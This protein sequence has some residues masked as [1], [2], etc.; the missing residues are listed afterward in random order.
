M[1][2]AVYYNWGRWIADC[3]DRDCYASLRVFPTGEAKKMA[4]C[5]C[6][7]RDLCG[8]DGFHGL[9]FSLEWPD[10]SSIEA[11]CAPRPKKNRNW[12]P[13]E[14]IGD[15]RRENEAHGVDNPI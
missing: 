10:V 9:A 6:R 1:R 2:A 3:P 15:L 14:T 8:H 7:E 12:Y 5:D 11:V 13:G 4:V